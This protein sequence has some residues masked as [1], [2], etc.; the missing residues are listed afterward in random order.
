MIF[1]MELDAAKREGHWAGFKL[2]LV[3]ASL[4]WFL[5]WLVLWVP[6]WMKT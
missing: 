4:I 2:G 6:E 3:C 1:K 5:V